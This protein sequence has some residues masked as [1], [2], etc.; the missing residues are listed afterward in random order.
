[1]LVGV[2][3]LIAIIDDDESL[4]TALTGLVRSL[5]YRAQ[6]YPDAEAFLAAPHT[7]A[8]ACI[9]TDIH[10]PGLSGI[11]L[12]H[13]LAAEGVVAPVIMITGRSEPGLEARVLASGACCLL[14]KPFDAGALDA[15]IKRAVA[16]PG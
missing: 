10:M 9:V 11:D 2:E 7:Q 12:R 4:R 14:R 3:P 5:G 15:C 16:R 13:R 8:I 1:M 6:A